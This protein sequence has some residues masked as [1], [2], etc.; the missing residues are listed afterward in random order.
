MM[1]RELTHITCLLER[2]KSQNRASTG[3]A[4]KQYSQILQGLRSIAELVPDHDTSKT[5]IVDSHHPSCRG[6][7]PLWNLFWT[8]WSYCLILLSQPD[9]LLVSGVVECSLP[10]AIATSVHLQISEISDSRDILEGS[11]AVKLVE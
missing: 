6:T 5:N 3:L 11:S 4:V 10:L 9:S 8:L 1:I 2:P 7:S